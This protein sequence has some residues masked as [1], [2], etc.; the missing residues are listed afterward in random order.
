MI[1]EIANIITIFSTFCLIDRALTRY[2]KLNGIYY[3]LHA[4][5]NDVIVYLTAEEVL[6]SLTDFNYILTSKKNMLALEFVFALHFYHL[7]L[8]WRKF[9]FDDW[10]HHILMIGIVLPIGWVVDSKS[11][12][13]YAL[14]FTTG[15]PGSIDYVL[16]FLTRNNVLDKKYEKRINAYLNT[17]IRSPGCVSHATLTMVLVS[18]LYTMFSLDWWLCVIAASS[19]LW[20][21]Q[22]F[23]RQVVENNAL[24]TQLQDKA[25]S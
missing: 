19:T 25:M 1:L 5:H 16:L 14:F 24:H 18:V 12:L 3:L 11:L 20:N 15:L 4:I 23:M 2:T 9:Q 13:G 17:W 6:C 21:G 22:Y 8:Y 10:I 7:A